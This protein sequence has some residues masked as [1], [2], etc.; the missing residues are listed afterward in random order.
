MAAATAIFVA[1]LVVFAPTFLTAGRIPVK[2]LTPQITPSST[3]TYLGGRV[4]FNCSI[5]ILSRSSNPFQ[6]AWQADGLLGPPIFTNNAS[7][8]LDVVVNK[9]SYNNTN[10]YCLGRYQGQP[11]KVYSS[12]EG[13]ILI[14]GM[15]SNKAESFTDTQ[16]II[17]RPPLCS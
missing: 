5:N 14:Q 16:I 2:N 10:V 9:V 1:V 6:L 11:G 12:S 7:I 8:T 17:C 15:S 4:T 13:T 3:T